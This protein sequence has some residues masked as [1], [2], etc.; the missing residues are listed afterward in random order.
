M[1]D[2]ET[3]NVVREG[4]IDWLTLNRPERLNAIDATMVRELWDYFSRLHQDYACRVV[5]MRGAG[6]GYCAG[7]DLKWFQDGSEAMPSGATDAGP[8]PSLSDIVLKMR[9]CPQPIVSLVHGAACG[10]GFIFALAS[11]IRIAGR[12][13]KM[14]VTFVKLGLS[15]C[16]L[17]TSFFLPRIV[18]RSVASELMMTGRFLHA[19]RALATGLVSEVVDDDAL[20]TAA[21]ALLVDLLA[22]SPI[23]LRKTK[24]VLNQAAEISDL[25]AVMA[26]EERTQLMCIDAGGF[27]QT[28]GAF[29]DKKKA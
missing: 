19:D 20:E 4:A 25:A 27:A 17:G 12:S 8:G 13:A 23:G 2:Y 5:V 16:E 10:G 26:L 11:D 7:L 24:E 18:G 1:Q 29:G 9:S 14:N 15:G 28:V 22:T 6:K 3:I 21:R